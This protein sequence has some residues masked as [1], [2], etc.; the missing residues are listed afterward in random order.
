M[1]RLG[2]ELD[3]E[4]MSLYRHLQSRDSLLDGIVETLMDELHGDP[5]VDFEPVHG[6][7]EYLIRLAHSLRRLARRPRTFP[8]LATRP[9]EAPWIRPPVRSLHWVES[10]LAALTSSGFSDRAAVDAYRAFSSFLLGHLLLEVSALGADL[11]PAEE[12][13]P[14]PPRPADLAGYPIL[15]R[16]RDQ[17]VADRSGQE[18]EES[19][20]HPAGPARS[21]EKLIL[22]GQSSMQRCVTNY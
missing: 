1:R 17:L 2:S 12:L 6:W 15:Q 8:L 21:T 18:F 16:L 7:Q 14:R 19:L 13:D 10:F 5:E 20:E 11:G 3:V 9:T 22:S 4:G